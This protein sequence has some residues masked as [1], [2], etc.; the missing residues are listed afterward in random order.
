MAIFNI[1]QYVL[2]NYFRHQKLLHKMICLLSVHQ[3][4][5][6]YVRINIHLIC[7]SL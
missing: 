1:I 7:L 2:V 5:Q 6:C 4:S 3:I